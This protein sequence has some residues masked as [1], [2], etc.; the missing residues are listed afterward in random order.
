MKKKKYQI[1]FLQKIKIINIIKIKMYNTFNKYT[2]DYQEYANMLGNTGAGNSNLNTT[3]IKMNDMFTF[4]PYYEKKI[5]N[6][7]YSLKNENVLKDYEKF[8]GQRFQY[9]TSFSQEHKEINVPEYERDSIELNTGGGLGAG[10][11]NR[12]HLWRK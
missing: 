11:F 3:T 4:Y 9:N 6:E 10:F 5:Q 1:F 2:K 8:L 7:L 12:S